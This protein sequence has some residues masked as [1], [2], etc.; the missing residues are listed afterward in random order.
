M[1]A[2]TPQNERRAELAGEL[3]RETTALHSAISQARIA[4]KNLDAVVREDEIISAALGDQAVSLV[5]I[6]DV[7]DHIA[8][9]QFD[10]TAILRHPL[11]AALVHDVPTEVDS[12]QPKP[13]KKSTARKAA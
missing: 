11:I 3:I 2:L 10:L 6:I 12:N 7:L 9:E 4:L 13:S 1:A 8:G 5:T